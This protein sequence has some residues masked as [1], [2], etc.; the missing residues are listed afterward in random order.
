M[1][2][3]KRILT[4]EFDS[5]IIGTQHDTLIAVYSMTKIIKKL[6]KNHQMDYFEAKEYFE[7][8]IKWK[9]DANEHISICVDDL[10]FLI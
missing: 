3:I 2:D 4:K 6:V 8:E 7:N 1:D 10:H 5:A 9:F